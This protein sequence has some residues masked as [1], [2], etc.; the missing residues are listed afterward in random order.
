MLRSIAGITRIIAQRW[1]ALLAWYLAGSLV[2]VSVLALAAPIGPQSPLAALLIVPIAVLARLVSYIG[3]FLV[4]RSALRNYSVVSLGDVSFTSLRD[5]A[6]EF[7]SVLVASIIPFFALYTLVGEL[8]VDFNDYARSAFKYSL[9]SEGGVLDVGDSPLVVT[10]VI[11]AFALRMLLKKFGP[12]LP[13]WM[14]LL[15]IYLEATWVFVALTGISAVLGTFL[16]W[17]ENRQLVFWFNEARDAVLGIWEP[18]RTVLDNT[19]WVIPAI[20]QLVLLPLAWLLIAGVIYTRSL[21][22]AVEERLV[23]VKI[24]ARLR[25]RVAKL[26]RRLQNQLHLFS[27]EWD[28]IGGPVAMGGRMIV[29][30]GVLNLTIFVVAYGTLFAGGQW[31]TRG[32]FTVVGAGEPAFWTVWIPLVTVGVSAVVEPLRIA[33]LAVAFDFALGRWRERRMPA[34]VDSDATV[35]AVADDA[36]TVDAPTATATIGQPD[37]A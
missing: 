16:D 26:P 28:D 10:V 4:V 37:P 15:E 27:D 3:M 23:S 21:S 29:R 7:M 33:L 22:T 36:V 31:L 11:V 34:S 19:E 6:S 13:K 25:T 1:P 8:S 2:R 32:V 14:A 9:G 5:A 17:I 20:A 12:R 24:E 30:S 35:H 18:I